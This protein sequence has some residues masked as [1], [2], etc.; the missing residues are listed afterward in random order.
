MRLELI[1]QNFYDPVKMVLHHYKLELWRRYVTTI[2]QHEDNIMPCCE[3]SHKIIRMDTVLEQI[4]L[5]SNKNRVNYRVA[6]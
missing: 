2:Q 6:C 3:I 5:I 1:G 4:V